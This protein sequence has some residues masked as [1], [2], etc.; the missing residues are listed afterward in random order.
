MTIFALNLYLVFDI[1]SEVQDSVDVS[2]VTFLSL[3][4]KTWCVVVQTSNFLYQISETVVVFE[5]ISL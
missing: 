5:V 1:D 4:Y 3:F 2:D